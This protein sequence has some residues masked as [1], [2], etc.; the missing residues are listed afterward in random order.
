MWTFPL[1]TQATPSRS[2]SAASQRLRARSWRQNGRW[3]S[4]RKRSRPNTATSRRPSSAAR[5]R[6]PRSQRPASAPSRAHP[7]RHTSPSLRSSSDS[8]ERTGGR[9]SRVRMRPGAQVCLRD[10][11]AEVPVAGGV[12]D[13]QCEVKR[14]RVALEHRHLCARYGMDA[15]GR[16]CL[17][18]LHRAPEAVVVG[19]RHRRVAQL[20]RPHRQFLRRGGAVAERVGGVGVQ[21]DVPRRHHARCSNQR[22]LSAGSRKTTRLRP[23]A[24]TS[25]K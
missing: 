14:F 8:S 24:R 17:G 21:L 13:E 10:Q 3:S 20:R 2:A 6:S 4:T 7:D 9:G 5:S 16:A 15:R 1:A 23:S 18:E 25:S 19:Q 12:F 22:P 11:P